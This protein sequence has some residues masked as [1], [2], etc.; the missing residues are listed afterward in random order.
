MNIKLEGYHGY[1]WKVCNRCPCDADGRCFLEY[2]RTSGWL[3]TDSGRALTK[4]ERVTQ[5]LRDELRG[6]WH[7]VTLRPQECI[8]KQGK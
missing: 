2:E 6:E 8:D 7:F 5:E 3:D 1:G 4:G